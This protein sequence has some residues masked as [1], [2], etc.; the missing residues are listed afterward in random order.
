MTYHIES[1]ELF[2][3]ETKPGRIAFKLGAAA[4]TER[5]TN[6]LVHVR[7]RLRD[8]SG[9]QTWGTAGD[10]LSVRWLDKRPGRDRGLKL[11]ELVD[12]IEFS[13]V[14]YLEQPEFASPFELWRRCHDRILAAG[15]QRGQEDLTSSFA[16]ALFERAVV[17][18]V[19]RALG[20]P[21]YQLVR[22]GQLGIDPGLV[23]PELEHLNFRELLPARPRTRF[24]VRHSVFNADLLSP[25]E[26]G[27]ERIGDGLP[28][29]LAENIDR[30]GIRFFK[31]K[32]SGNVEADLGRLTDVWN[33][34][35]KDPETTVT[36]DANEAYADLASFEQLVQQMRSR[37]PG[38]FDHLA[39][40]EQPLRRALTLDPATSPLIRKINSIKPLLIDEADA[41]VDAYR[42]AYAI[43]YSGT[44]HKNCKGFFKSLLN[45]ALV[46]HYQTKDQPAFLSGEDLQNLPIVP[47]HQDFVAVSLLGLDNCER[48][49]H[50][51]NYGLSMLSPLDKASV[52]RRHRD[53][54]ERRGDEWFLKIRDGMVETASLHGPGFGVLDEP[55]FASMEPLRPWVQRRFP[56]G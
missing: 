20:K 48:N 31:V 56:A 32:I 33:V 25:D 34:L 18:G 44:S 26:L 38:L 55:D 1:I 28:E 17:D 35:P 9:R 47:L 21:T 54:Y 6:P 51:L 42:R 29:T 41:T 24:F 7:M 12:L 36:L 19:S 13:R 5:R 30:Y 43:G 40:I 53:L 8:A 11:R 45:A 27:S 4:K 3:R 50:H 52:A 15:R 23:H 14:V 46:A 16:S 39:Y 22:E 37:I 2:L 49:G 10:R